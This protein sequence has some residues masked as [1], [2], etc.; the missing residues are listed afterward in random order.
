MTKK[1]YRELEEVKVAY[2]SKH[3]YEISAYIGAVLED[4]QEEGDKES[5]YRSL[6]ILTKVHGGF[7]KI[8]RETGLNRESLYK[9]LYKLS[10]LR[11]VSLDIFVKPPCTFVKIASDL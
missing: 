1:K 6:A 7:T 4:F 11:P 9:A 2:Y 5:F 8:S 10:L 3:P